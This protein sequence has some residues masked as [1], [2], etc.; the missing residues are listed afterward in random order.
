ML[1]PY[2]QTDASRIDESAERDVATLKEIINACRTL[3][4]EMNLQPGQKVPLIAQG[5]RA[6]L[7]TYTPYLMAL[8]RLTEVNIV[9][10]L[11]AA[12]APVSIVGEFKLMLKIE[13]DKAAERARLEKE[14]DRIS[15]EITKADAQLNN[16]HFV[17]KAPSAVV[18]QARERL[19][20][21]KTTL[22]DIEAQLKKLQS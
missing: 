20:K 4:S 13:I 3:R 18:A 9:D 5:D 22:A 2:P 10:T 21:F 7:A 11:P 19:A 16:P 14:R 12:D 17:D 8:A 1:Q 15:A 6:R